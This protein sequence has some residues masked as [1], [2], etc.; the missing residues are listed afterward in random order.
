MCVFYTCQ[1]GTYNIERAGGYIWRP[2]TCGD[3]ERAVI[4]EQDQLDL[5]EIQDVRK[6]DFILNSLNGSIVSLGFAAS[7]SYI[8]GQP[9]ELKAAFTSWDRSRYDFNH[10]FRVDVSY[11]D[12]DKP[13]VIKD[14]KAWLTE[15]FHP[16]STFTPEGGERGHYI[17]SLK[18]DYAIYLLENIINLQESINL[19]QLLSGVLEEIAGASGNENDTT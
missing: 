11:V 2:L 13:L 19:R 6:G 14:H 8:A 15:H 10:G 1:G 9:D 3:G 16:N 18:N 12:F 17:S 7:D 4:L 5:I